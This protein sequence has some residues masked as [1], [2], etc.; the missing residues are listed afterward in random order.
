VKDEEG[1]T[2]KKQ[3][4]HGIK[5]ICPRPD[6]LQ[7]KYQEQEEGNQTKHIPEFQQ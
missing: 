1:Q 5:T 4:N 3:I 6:G 2:E 7:E